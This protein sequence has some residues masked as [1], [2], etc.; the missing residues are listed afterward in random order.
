M[1]VGIGPVYG[2]VDFAPSSLLLVGIRMGRSLNLRR[3]PV[4]LET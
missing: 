3:G 2:V 1:Q 4:L